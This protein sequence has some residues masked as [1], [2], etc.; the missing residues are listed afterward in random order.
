MG[1]KSITL[2]LEDDNR[3]TL[4]ALGL[5]FDAASTLVPSSW[6]F[7]PPNFGWYK[8]KACMHL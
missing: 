8:D 7:T 4:M 2:E 5:I 6:A 3:D 1:L